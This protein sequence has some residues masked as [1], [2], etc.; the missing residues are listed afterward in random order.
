[1][2]RTTIAISALMLG[3]NV[4][5]AQSFDCSKAS[6]R[7]E[8]MICVDPEIAKLD[9]EMAQQYKVLLSAL[10]NPSG[11]L[12]VQRRWLVETR[13]VAGAPGALKEV[14]TDRL[15]YLRI[16]LEC[17]TSG[18]SDTTREL[19]TCAFIGFDSSDAELREVYRKL[20][21]EPRAEP[22][23]E[24]AVALKASQDAWLKFRD[25]QCE[26]D[27]FEW[28]G[29][30]MRPTVVFNCQRALTEERIRQLKGQR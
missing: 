28:G 15:D 20:L 29:G 23:K 13:N 16:A 3:T 7:T 22:V 4:A 14:Y 11:V 24:A 25:L 2:M 21:A 17:A 6:T 10:K 26:W 8:Q 9:A 30:S 12:A 27:T 5:A 18:G 19:N 1:M